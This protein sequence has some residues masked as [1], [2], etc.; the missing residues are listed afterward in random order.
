MNETMREKEAAMFYEVAKKK[1]SGDKLRW[2]QGWYQRAGL[3]N[4][5]SYQ[6]KRQ[7]QTEQSRICLLPIVI[8][9]KITPTE[10]R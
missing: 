4:T 8:S 3:S 1:K 10:A 6:R 2:F 9:D 7:M 5:G